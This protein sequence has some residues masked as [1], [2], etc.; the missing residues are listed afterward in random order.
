MRKFSFHT[1]LYPN[2]NQKAELCLVSIKQNWILIRQF[3]FS[4]SMCHSEWAWM[5]LN[6]KKELLKIEFLVSEVEEIQKYVLNMHTWTN[7]V[8]YLFIWMSIVALVLTMNM[9]FHLSINYD[10]M[11]SCKRVVCFHYNNKMHAS[12]KYSYDCFFSYMLEWE[13]YPGVFSKVNQIFWYGLNCFWRVKRHFSFKNPSEQHN[14]ANKA[15]THRQH[16][17]ET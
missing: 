10:V 17:R 2:Y 15:L 16:V 5:T 6:V 8:N 9:Q 14:V 3:Y 12:S 13:A 1:Q 7:L 4:I 11:C